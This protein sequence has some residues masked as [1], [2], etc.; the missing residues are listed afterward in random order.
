MEYSV[1]SLYSGFSK[2]IFEP[3]WLCDLFQ[4]CLLFT[5]GRA[6][7]AAEDDVIQC[8]PSGIDAFPPDF[9]SQEQRRQGGVIVHVVIVCYV[10]AMLA[11]V[12]D[13]YFVP[14]LEAIAESKNTILL[15]M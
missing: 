14:A 5:P 11:I 1:S 7:L 13:E 10:C 3:W 8:I 6:P 9:L 12:C 15:Q 2:V 4:N